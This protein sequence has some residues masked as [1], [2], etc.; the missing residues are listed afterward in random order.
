MLRSRFRTGVVSLRAA[1]DRRIVRVSTAHA[2]LQQRTVGGIVHI[3]FYDRRID[4]KAAAVRH[5]RPLRHLNDLSMQL[6]DDLGAQRAGDL[7][8]RLRIRHFVGVNAGERA[9]DQIRPHL[10]FQVVVAPVEQVLQDQHP[11][12]DLRRC[13]RP[14]ASTTL[15]PSRLE[16]LRDDLNHG[17]VL[18]QR[19]DPPQP[20]GPQLVTIGQQ[21]FE[22]TPLALTAS[23]HARSFVACMRI[24]I[25]TLIRTGKRSKAKRS[26]TRRSHRSMNHNDLTRPFFTGK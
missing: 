11:N 18:E 16:R 26:V 7:Q 12:H 13:P 17:L 22:E 6:L 14:A 19:V 23:D 20:V 25:G 1:P 8:D 5:P 24:N 15:R 9:I 21:H 4:A 2:I 10:L 3:G